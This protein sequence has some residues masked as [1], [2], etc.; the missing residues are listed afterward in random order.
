MAADGELL[1]KI[2]VDRDA[3]AFA[4]FYDRHAPGMFAVA[5]TLLGSRTD[6]EDA[7][8]QTFLNLFQSRRGFA[9]AQSPRAVLMV[10]VKMRRQRRR[11]PARCSNASSRS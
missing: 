1:R 8:Q 5:R 4:A 6:A 10:S 7:V 3:E 11:K 9:S 2:D